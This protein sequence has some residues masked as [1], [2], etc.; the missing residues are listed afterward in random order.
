VVSRS[1][2]SD[3]FATFGVVVAALSSCASSQPSA[4]GC[5]PSKFRHV[6]PLVIAHASSNYFGP[7]NTIEMMR[8]AVAAGADVVDAD[9]RVTADGVLVASHD[10]VIVRP[11]GESAAIATS[12][13]SELQNIDAA[14]HWAGPTNTFPLRGKG[15]RMPTIEEIL[16]AFP[17][18]RLVSLEFKV[19][20][21][22]ATLC[23][24]LRRLGRTKDVY[25]GSAGDAAV[26][27]FRPLCPEVVTTVTDAMV[28]I[29]QGERVKPSSTWCSNVPIGQ[30]PYD[31]NGDRLVTKESTEWD[32][33]HGLAVFTWT[34]DDPETLKEVATSGAD[35]VYTGRADLAR[36]IFDAS[37][38]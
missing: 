13:V 3:R 19:T 5:A 34:I 4:V 22:E 33:R 24:L 15:V 23:Q 26:D 18:P 7:G 28:P 25:I 16:I 32:H 8:A 36:K 2:F 29:M 31:I 17:S 10:D 35:G 27:T 11:T 37:S 14:A 1:R 12:K 38:Q 9:V 20:G 6:K 30:P 21:G